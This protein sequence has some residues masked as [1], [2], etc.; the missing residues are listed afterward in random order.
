MAGKVGE[1]FLRIQPSIIFISDPLFSHLFFFSVFLV[2]SIDFS[3]IY[4]K[5]I[6]VT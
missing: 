2:S 5:M 4:M 6:E 1:F 3:S